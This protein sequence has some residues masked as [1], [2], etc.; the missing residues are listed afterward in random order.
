MRTR[1][2][3]KSRVTGA[4]AGR[5]TMSASGLSFRMI[6]LASLMDFPTTSGHAFVSSTK[7]PPAAVAS[8]GHAFREEASS[9]IRHADGICVCDPTHLQLD[10]P[11]AC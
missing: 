1:L 11:R 2:G 6:S 4:P 7:R 3:L 5:T 9:S 10:G 8:G